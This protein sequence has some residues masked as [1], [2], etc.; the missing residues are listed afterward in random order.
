MFFRKS[1]PIAPLPL[2]M[3]GVKMGERLLQIGLDSASLT[4]ALAAKVG[5]SGN[6]AHILNKDTDVTRA[7]DAAAKAG[8]A[9]DVRLVSTYRS[10]PFDDESFDLIVIHSMHGLLAGMAP[11]T[12]VRCLEE[13]HRVLRQGGRTIVIEPEPRGGL[14]GLFR[15][16]QVDSHYAAT[17]ETIGALKAEGFKPVRVLA[18][19]EGYRFIE[20]MKT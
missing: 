14:G 8:A 2:T 10:F 16:Y 9:S 19:R 4:A 13:A 1:T 3:T 18:D 15:T 17:G 5:M 6:A 12:R 11:Y 7:R 20:G